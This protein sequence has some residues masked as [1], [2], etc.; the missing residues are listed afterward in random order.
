MTTEES[1]VKTEVPVVP[2]DEIREQLKRMAG[3]CDPIKGISLASLVISERA[4][5][6]V[7][8]GVFA[9]KSL[10]SIAYGL[11]ELGSGCVTGIDSW[12][13][14]DS[15]IDTDPKDAEWWSKNVN[16]DAIYQECLGHISKTGLAQHIRLLRM[17]S[18]TA[19]K[20]LTEP[21]D[22]LHIDGCH[23]EWSSTSDVTLWLP[24][25]RKGGIVVM[26]DVNWDST[27]TAIRMVK[28]WCD[29]MQVSNTPESVFGI[30]R[31]RV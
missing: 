14:G 4:Q 10:L 15:L 27:Q 24:L 28:K 13:V 29:E 5:R 16:L 30:Y 23:S 25:V 7:E 11:R 18:L 21:I 22:L 19:A 12:A 6:C 31:K 8:I 26:D 9:G 17:S 20:V 2:A 3:W 1:A